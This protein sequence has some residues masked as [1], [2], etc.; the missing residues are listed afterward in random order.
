MKKIKNIFLIIRVDL[1]VFRVV[2]IDYHVAL[3]QFCVELIQIHVFFNHYN[4]FPC[5]INTFTNPNPV[6]ALGNFR[7]RCK[8]LYCYIINSFCLHC[9]EK[10]KKK[11]FFKFEKMR[12]SFFNNF[13]NRYLFWIFKIRPFFA[14]IF[15][16]LTV[17]L[18]IQKFTV[19]NQKSVIH[20]VFE[21]SVIRFLFRRCVPHKKT[22]RFSVIP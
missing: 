20:T 11:H 12:F 13:F 18:K 5:G 9:H 1:I 2:L 16:P 22:Y 14:L 7:N 3:I 19:F 21:L 15:I 17:P 6:A 4:S 8:L 10:I